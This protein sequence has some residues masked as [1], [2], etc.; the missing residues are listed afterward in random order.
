MLFL[1]YNLLL[2]SECHGDAI[3]VR[4]D[5]LVRFLCL[6]RSLDLLLFQDAVC[7]QNASGNGPRNHLLGKRGRFS[8]LEAPG[9][10]TDMRGLVGSHECSE[11]RIR[12]SPFSQ[13]LQ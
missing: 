10:E 4:E 12:H 5:S 3:V 1:L 7:L 13:T 9:R 6:S 2:C 8:R 11:K